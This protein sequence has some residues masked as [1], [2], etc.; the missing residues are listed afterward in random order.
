MK[1]YKF[2]FYFKYILVNIFIAVLIVLFLNNYIVSAAK[3]EGNSMQPSLK[4]KDRVLI[5]KF[6]KKSN[7]IK[8]FDI[9][10]FNKPR[11]PKIS[12]IKRVIGLPNEIIKIENGNV[13][14]N[15]TL[16]KQTF[17]FKEKLFLKKSLNIKALKISENHFFVLGD[18]R[19]NSNDSRAFGPVPEKNIS[20]KV[21]LR[22]WPLSKFGKIK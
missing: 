11:E 10:V 15:N 6:L 21:F 8:R 22:Y 16:L 13:Y 3:I 9:I 4:S 17:L 20:G 7:N 14:I 5:S 19:N 18:N 12:I 2:K 1:N